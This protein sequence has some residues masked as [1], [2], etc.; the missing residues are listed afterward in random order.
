M[1]R[2][3][4]LT[5]TEPPPGMEEEFNAWYDDEHLPERLGIPGF[6]SARRW[7]AAAGRA[8]LATYELDSP[9][10]LSSPEYLHRYQNQTPWSRR[11][12]GKCVVFKRWACEQVDPGDAD[13][14]PAARAVMLAFEA[15]APAGALQVRRF[16]AASGETILLCE[17]SEARA[18]G[19]GV[20]RIYPS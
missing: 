8:Y 9:A 11:C 14:H 13:P 16:A 1:R 5:L 3:L 18:T 7:K 12:L 17:L 4:L 15:V 6:R 20:Y 2:G 19:D 10:V